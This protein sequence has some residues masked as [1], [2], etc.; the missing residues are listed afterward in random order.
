[1]INLTIII[2]SPSVFGGKVCVRTSGDRSALGA[3]WQIQPKVAF[4]AW[5]IV[6]SKNP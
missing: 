1:M 3:F 6:F 2:P 4:M 5:H